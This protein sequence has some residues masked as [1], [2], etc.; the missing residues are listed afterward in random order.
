MHAAASGHLEVVTAL[1][2][3]KPDLQ[4]KSTVGVR[5]GHL[6]CG[7]HLVSHVLTSHGAMSRP[8]RALVRVG[9]HWLLRC[10]HDSAR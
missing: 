1:L 7:T 2:A 5:R 9:T 10:A 3:C 4:I 8:A 6:W